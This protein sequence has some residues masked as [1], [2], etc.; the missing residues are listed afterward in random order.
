MLLRRVLNG[1]LGGLITAVGLSGCETKI[2]QCNQLITIVNQV[3]DDLSKVQTDV[4]ASGPTQD[5]DQMAAQLEQFTAS[6]EKNIQAMGAIGVDAPLK[7]FQQNLVATYKTALNNS[8]TLTAAVK[9]KNQPAAQTA[10]N[11]LN[12]A[13]GS[14]AKALKAIGDYCKV[15]Q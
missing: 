15:P 9:A 10:L 13:G 3:S 2:S 11:A 4:R 7:P 8:R 14:E 6:L 1:L 5:T 12:A